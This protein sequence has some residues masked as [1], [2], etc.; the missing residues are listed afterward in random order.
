MIITGFGGP[1]S[2]TMQQQSKIAERKA[3]WRIWDTPRLKGSLYLLYINQ[4]RHTYATTPSHV[5]LKSAYK[6][7]TPP[8]RLPYMAQME[9]ARAQYIADV[10]A[11]NARIPLSP[12]VE[13]TGA[14]SSDEERGFNESKKIDD[15]NRRLGAQIWNRYRRDHA[16]A[17]GGAVTPVPSQPFRFLDLPLELRQAIYGLILHVPTVVTQME[18]DH[19]AN[20]T[21]GPIDTRIFAVSKRI[22]EEATEAFFH[23]NVGFISLGDD[24]KSG[25]AVPM[26]R[27]DA[28]ELQQAYI[29]K[30][31]KVHIAIP[32]RDALELPRFRW[33]LERVC[34]ALA[35]S[36]R[37]QEV[38]VTPF[39]L[40]TQDRPALD[41]AMDDMLEPITLLAG[42]TTVKFTDED[43]LSDFRFEGWRVIGTKA[44]RDRLCSI[45][46]GPTE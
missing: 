7:M 41:V 13:Y 21:E 25:L 23:E 6:A 15:C 32:M 45:V 20:D 36:P 33:I 30:L 24:H 40:S 3:R 14:T 18:P 12:L 10:Q 43:A 4:I 17:C 35:Q 8:E 28:S 39:T 46:N 37:L 44:Q 31:A 2:H 38:R 42:G 27:D 19:T 26:F 11:F 16:E 9:K 34:Q 5:D 1:S 29:K 22:H